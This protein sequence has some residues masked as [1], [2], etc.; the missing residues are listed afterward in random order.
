MGHFRDRLVVNDLF[1]DSRQWRPIHSGRAAAVHLDQSD[2]NLQFL[3]QLEAEVIGDFGEA[4]A[5]PRFVAA[6]RVAGREDR[7]GGADDPARGFVEIVA[8][9]RL[10]GVVEQ[11]N[12]R[13]VGRFRRR[14][15]NRPPHIRLPRADPDFTEQHVGQRDRV[16]PLHD[17]L[18]RF[19]RGLERRQLA[20][21]FAAAVR[22]DRRRIPGQRHLH[23][24]ARR[25]RAPDDDRHLPL[26][27]HV[28]GEERRQLDIGLQRAAHE[29][30]DRQAGGDKDDRWPFRL[31]GRHGR[32]T[33]VDFSVISFNPEPTATACAASH[34]RRWLRVK[35]TGDGWLGQSAACPRGVTSRRWGALRFAPSTPASAAH[36]GLLISSLHAVPESPRPRP[37]RF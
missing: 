34:R 25:G 20:A 19:A 22:H 31:Q 27:H 4:A 1:R 14:V 35:R 23:R 6:E 16:L 12:L 37:G 26:K 17:Q 21:P 11:A 28:I 36:P 24:L 7:L 29:A 8:A 2:R 33:Q 18:Q 9:G 15:A 30:D 5:L 13:L 3:V 32:A 10:A